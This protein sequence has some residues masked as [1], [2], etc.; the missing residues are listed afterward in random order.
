VQGIKTSDW[1]EETNAQQNKNPVFSK[2]LSIKET[3]PIH[4]KQKQKSNPMANRKKG[5]TM[6]SHITQQ[7]MN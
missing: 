2:T 5:Q 7:R 3:N 6:I 4:S 1:S